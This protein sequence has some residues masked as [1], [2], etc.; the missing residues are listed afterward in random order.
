MASAFSHAVVALAIGR[1]GT[2]A[3]MPA[4][5]WWMS[6]ACSILPDADVLSFAFGVR[7]GDVLGHRGLTHS[8]SFCR[9]S[10]P[11]CCVMVVSGDVAPRGDGGF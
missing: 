11:C 6:V 2:G 5:F 1:A 4:R 3:A 10:E 9:G 8:L 7:Y